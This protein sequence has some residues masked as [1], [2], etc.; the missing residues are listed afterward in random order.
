[1]NAQRKILRGLAAALIATGIV[2]PALAQPIGGAAV[3]TGPGTATASRVVTVTA[4]VTAIDMTTR[5][6]TLRRTDGSSFTVVANE[7]ARNLPQVRVGDTVTVDFYDSA[8]ARAQEGG[9]GAPASRTYSLSG[10]RAELGQR[11]GGSPPV[12]R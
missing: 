12:R 7:Q 4:T 5:Q 10:S 6:V 3:T 8:G 9:T 1:M 11:P 2:V